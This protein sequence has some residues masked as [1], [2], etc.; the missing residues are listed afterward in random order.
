MTEP[1]GPLADLP[2]R[3]LTHTETLMVRQARALLR[4]VLP[5]TMPA[6]AATAL[7]VLDQ[8]LDGTDPERPGM[9]RDGDDGIT[10]AL[11]RAVGLDP[12]THHGFRLTVTGGEW[13]MVE[14]L[15]VPPLAEDG[16]IARSFVEHLA[17]HGRQLLLVPADDPSAML[18]GS[19]D[20]DF[21]MI[22]GLVSYDGAGI[23]IDEAHEL[24]AGAKVVV[25]VPKHDIEMVRSSMAEPEHVE[26]TEPEG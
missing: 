23:D 4:E 17:A 1:T 11:H 9:H 26:G 5:S 3:P 16:G 21:D 15:P 25:L 6:G 24:P 13:P 12:A 8:A 7:D 19:R 20:T 10:A 2:A 18:L 22:T 14:A